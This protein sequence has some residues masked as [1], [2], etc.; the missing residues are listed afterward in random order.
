[1]SDCTGLDNVHLGLT[2]R[3]KRHSIG[4]VS[5]EFVFTCSPG[6]KKFWRLH[7]DIVMLPSFPVRVTDFSIHLSGQ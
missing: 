1:M 2:V 6:S 5:A 4:I 7:F 3:M